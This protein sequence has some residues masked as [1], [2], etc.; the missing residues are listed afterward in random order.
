MIF[1][2]FLRVK[3]NWTSPNQWVS[4]IFNHASMDFVTKIFD[5]AMFSGHNNRHIIIRVFSFGLGINSNQ[6]Q[7]LPHSINQVIK[8]PS[9]VSC[10]WNVVRNL[11]Q[12]V[13]LIKCNGIDF[14]QSVKTWNI[15][16]IAFYNIDDIVFCSITL[17]TKVSIVYT[18]FSQNGFNS[19][20]TNP[21]S[22]NHSWNGDSA[23][24]FFSEFNQRWHFIQSNTETF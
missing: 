22:V 21:I 20:V 9:K 15:F 8:I 7:I 16:T 14:V 13:K 3:F 2:D 18:I 11:I 1:A 23:F 5:W 12:N 4:E 19:L 24:V 6:I 10:D 17:N